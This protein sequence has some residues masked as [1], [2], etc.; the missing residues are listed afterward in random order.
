MQVNFF[1]AAILSLVSRV[2]NRSPLFDQLVLA[3]ANFNLLKGGVFVACLWWV[4][5]EPARDQAQRRRAVVVTVLGAFVG[6]VL[7]R[8]LAVVLPFRLR[9]MLAFHAADGPPVATAWHEWSSF[10]SDHATLFVA[11]GTGLLLATPRIGRPALIYAAV[12]VCAPRVYIGYHY[13]TDVVFA[14]LLGAACAWVANRT[15]IRESIGTRVL[16]WAAA[17]PAAFYA[18]AFLLSYEI[19]VLFAD[20][21]AAGSGLIKALTS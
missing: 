21:R 11:L 8:I 3:V 19:V 4:W 6:L 12:V 10:P 17:R 2:A 15:S 9:P 7:A 20:L 16:Q 13:S 18:G 14:A 1:D 5:F